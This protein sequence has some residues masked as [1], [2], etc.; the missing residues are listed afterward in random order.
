MRSLPPS[1]F[2]APATLLMVAGLRQ[3]HRRYPGLMG[4]FRALT[5]ATVAHAHVVLACYTRA[6]CHNEG[7]CTCIC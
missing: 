7:N 3:L 6:D 4:A 1:R 2:A 5:L